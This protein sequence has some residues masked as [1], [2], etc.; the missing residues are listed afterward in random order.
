MKYQKTHKE[1]TQPNSMRWLRLFVAFLLFASVLIATSKVV[2]ATP[3][4]D[5]ISYQLSTWN[6]TDGTSNGSQLTCA[7]DGSTS[8]TCARVAKNPHYAIRIEF[9]SGLSALTSGDTV[10]VNVKMLRGSGNMVLLPYTSSNGVSTTNKISVS[11]VVGNNVFTLTTAFINDLF[12]QGGGA[13]AF[14]LTTDGSL[15]DRFEYTEIETNLTASLTL[16]NH[17]S[18]QVADKFTTTSPVT[19][20]LFRFNLTRSGTVTVDTL[21]VNFT[22]AGGVVNGDVSSGEL[23]KDVNNDGVV[24]NP[25]DTLIQGSVTPSSGVLTFTSNF[26]PGTGGTNYLVRAT[27]ASLVAD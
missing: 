13:F 12:D 10:T 26:S 7:T 20:V 15:F 3:L 21:R 25:G 16:A 17:G 2:S 14:R 8:T 5:A 1:V 18:G 27:V 6:G 11:P 19:D 23:W 24:D 22:T 4:S 9:V